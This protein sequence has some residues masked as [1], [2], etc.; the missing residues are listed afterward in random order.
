MLGDPREPETQFHGHHRC[1]VRPVHYARVPGHVRSDN[2]FEFV[3][4]AVRDW[5]GA[6]DAKTAYIE[7][8]S[9]WENGYCELQKKSSNFRDHALGPFGSI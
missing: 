5:I 6:V 2:G 3:A 9:P 1:P 8:G 4:K 7:P